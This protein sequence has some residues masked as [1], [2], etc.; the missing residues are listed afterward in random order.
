MKKVF[1]IIICIA[2]AVLFFLSITQSGLIPDYFSLFDNK[3][4][5]QEKKTTSQG[6]PINEDF[7][8]SNVTMVSTPESTCFSEVGYDEAENTL[9]VTFRDSGSTYAYYDVS[10][11]VWSEFIA[12]ESK[13]S[14]YNKKI[15][16]NYDCE[17][18]E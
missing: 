15:K 16:G 11:S 3:T 17:K 5:V 1:T 4:I 6:T 2:A 10:S 7:D 9:V 8:D 18:I 14:Y 13:G 12:A